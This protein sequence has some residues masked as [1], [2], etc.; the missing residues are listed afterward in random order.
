VGRHLHTAEA[1]RC[2]I[3]V[4]PPAEILVERFRAVDI[5][6]AKQNNL[7]FHVDRFGLWHRLCLADYNAGHH[8]L[9]SFGEPYK[10]PLV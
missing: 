3:D 10:T 1:P 6:N 4:D 5:G 9:L 7:E 2:N 8:Y